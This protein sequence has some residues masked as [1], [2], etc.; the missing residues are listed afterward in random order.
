MRSGGFRGSN[1]S[2]VGARLPRALVIGS[3]T[4]FLLGLGGSSAF[5]DCPPTD[6]TCVTDVVSD[7]QQTV[8]GGSGGATDTIDEAVGG[9][10][11]TADAVA[12]QV[13]DTVDGILNPGGD[14]GGGGGGGGGG[15]HGGG[16]TGGGGTGSGNGSSGGRTD[17]PG[18]SSTSLQPNQPSVTTVASRSPVAGRRGGHGSLLGQVGDVIADAARQVAF[19]LALTLMVVAFL[20]I[21]NRLDRGDPKLAMAPI[22]PD[23]LRF[24]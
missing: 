23:V 21:Q 4:A 24:D 13:T 17:A 9:V 12:K 5:A 6:P 10:Q 7:A 16:G 8:T 20:L 1:S 14:D 18:G 2:S 19:P 11:D 3:F 15:G 22:G